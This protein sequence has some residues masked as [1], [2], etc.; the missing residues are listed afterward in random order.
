[1]SPL[2]PRPGGA[3]PFPTA[4]PDPA[5]RS[6]R[7]ARRERHFVA[8]PEGRAGRRR[9][10]AALA[11]GPPAEVRGAR[12]P[13]LAAPPRPAAA[14]PAP[15]DFPLWSFATKGRIQTVPRFVQSARRAP[16]RRLL[17][18]SRLT[19]SNQPPT[20]T[21][22]QRPG[23]HPISAKEQEHGLCVLS[24]HG[25]GG[26]PGQSSGALLPGIVRSPRRVPPPL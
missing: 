3:R 11:P 7:T 14:R 24:R 19:I 17:A 25:A 6:L 10:R 1:M 18:P 20:L 8:G 16:A 21:T 13:L 22:N 26:G 12:S 2:S 9:G 4:R 15:I 5:A 23:R